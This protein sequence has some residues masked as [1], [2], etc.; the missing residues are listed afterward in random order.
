MKPLFE[1]NKRLF[2][3]SVVITSILLILLL[4]SFNFSKFNNLLVPS[5]SILIGTIDPNN[6]NGKII[7]ERVTD[8]T[9]QLLIDEI[10]MLLLFAESDP[11]LSLPQATPDL[12][13]MIESPRNAT[14]I[15]EFNLW[16]QEDSAIIQ[17]RRG[18]DWTNFALKKSTTT[19][20][21]ALS[22]SF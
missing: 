19:E 5:R 7:K 18:E 20:L 3:R 22:D 21:Q 14:I 2:K 6:P 8:S 15:C 12:Y 1:K 16:W 9:N 13:C 4:I 17:I 11:S 10:E